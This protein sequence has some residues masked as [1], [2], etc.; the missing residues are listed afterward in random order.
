MHEDVEPAPLLRDGVEYGLE[1]AGHGHIE[2]QTADTWQYWQFFAGRRFSA[3]FASISGLAPAGPAS[4]AAMMAI[5]AM[6][7]SGI[8]AMPRLRGGRARS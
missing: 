7:T 5:A 1:L 6:L 3:A 4:I 8:Q 2:R